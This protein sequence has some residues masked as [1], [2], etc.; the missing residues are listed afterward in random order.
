MGNEK[1]LVVDD[2]PAIRH[3]IWKSLQSTGL[4]I[5]QSDSIT[6]TMDIISRVTFDLYLLDVSLE[7]D[8]DG[9]QLAQMIRESE[10]LVP[11]LFLSGKKSEEAIITGL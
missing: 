6:K 1:I 5:Y 11:I 4:L 2:D 9:Y 7:Y 10:P 3:L 8:N